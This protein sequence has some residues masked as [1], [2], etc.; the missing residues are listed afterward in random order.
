MRSKIKNIAIVGG[1]HGNEFTGAYL[2][3]YWQDNP[4]EIRRESFNTRAILANPKA[5][6]QVRRYVDRDL[7]RTCSLTRMNDSS[8]QTY[9]DT[10]ARSLR[11][12]LSNRVEFIVDLHTTTANMGAS[13]VVSSTGELTWACVAYLCEKF[14]DLKVYRWQGDIENAYVNSLAKDGFAIE[15]GAVP[16]GVL[17]GDVYAKSREMTLAVLD[18]IE[19]YNQNDIVNER[20]FM[21][22]DHVELVDYPRDSK[23]DIVAM[24]HP[25]LQDRDF[26]LLREGDAI[27]LG[28]DGK[29]TR[30]NKAEPLHT[31]FINEAAYYEKGFAFCL[32]REESVRLSCL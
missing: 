14:Q 2:A 15:V 1:T 23:G 31:L 26:T 12:E 19:L 28:F 32:A 18:F 29:V 30:Y 11:E 5:F 24:V 25:D 4:Q 10:L 6:E 27:F 17:R 21:I 7:N 16:Q 22:Y 8:C 9:E 13:L 3:K 20:E